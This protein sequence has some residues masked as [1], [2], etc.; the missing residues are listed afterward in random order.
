MSKRPRMK[1]LAILLPWFS[2]FLR[3]QY[4]KGFI[5]LALQITIIGWPVASVWAFV[6]LL[7]SGK[8]AKESFVIDSLRPYYHK[9]QQMQNK[10]IA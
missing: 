9:G 4:T 1:R 10:R 2:F 7:A 6:S 3:E 5:C 8:A